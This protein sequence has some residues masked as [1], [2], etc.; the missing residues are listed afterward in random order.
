MANIKVGQRIPIGG[1]LH[2]VQEV[3][4]R[5]SVHVAQ[6]DSRNRKHWCRNSP[7]RIYTGVRIVD[8]EA[9][10]VIR[11]V[12]KRLVLI[13]AQKQITYLVYELT[14]TKENQEDGT[15]HGRE[16]TE[17]SDREAVQVPA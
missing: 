6:E 8:Y 7:N 10:D 17:S 16:G 15:V 11:E 5:T 2:Y 1:Q 9:G 12:D 14:I 4:E 13:N 3:V